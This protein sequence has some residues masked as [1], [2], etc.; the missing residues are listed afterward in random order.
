MSEEINVRVEEK[1]KKY[2]EDVQK[3]IEKA[4]ELAESNTAHA[5]GELLGGFVRI[6]TKDTIEQEVL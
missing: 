5:V 6:L 4:L 1:L 3:L 2:P